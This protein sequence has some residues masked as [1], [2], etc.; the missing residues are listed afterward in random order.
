MVLSLFV[1]ETG[2]NVLV[3][4][5][6]LQNIGPEGTS[7]LKIGM[8]SLGCSK[9]LI[10]S[11]IMLGSLQGA[12]YDITSHAEAADVIVV[13]TCG[14]IESAKSESINTILEMA[15]HKETGRCRALI[16]AGCLSQRYSRELMEEIPEIDGMLGTGELDRLPELLQAVEEG[17]RVT[18]VSHPGFDYDEPLARVVT[19]APHS[20]YL[21][22][23]EGCS[24]S[25]AYCVIPSLRGPYRSRTMANILEEAQCLADNGARELILIAQDTSAYGKDL[26]DAPELPELLRELAK[27]P[28]IHWLRV[29]YTYPTTFSH[30]LIEEFVRNPKVCHYVDLPLQH[31]SDSVLVRMGRGPVAK[32][33]KRLIDNLR[34]A[35]P[36]VALRS[37]F[38]VGFPGE[39]EAEF[40]ELLSFLAEVRFDHVG[41]FSYS[42]EEGTPAAQLPDQVPE[43]IKEERYKRAMKLQQEI[44]EKKN[45]ARVGQ[46][47]EVIIDGPCE[48]TDLV[49]VARSQYQA[50]DV[51]GVIY[52]GNRWLPAGELAPARI[53]Q[54]HS[55]DLVAETMEVRGDTPCDG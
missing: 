50:P 25:C 35:M 44:S 23:A 1:N 34:S 52:I 54:G 13:N 17:Q 53:I 24:H 15:M 20:V 21:K 30:R 26:P 39:T 45:Q 27:I 22:I 5:Q 47:Y 41:I 28:E 49:L 19:T 40:Q 8:V 31:A 9:N 42:A 2:E 6:A 4:K 12:G 36:D 51:D 14:F 18:Y 10:D 3:Y 37:S 16:V 29:L 46:T 7:P 43:A 33:Q 55:Y 48:E 38:I 11:E 32:A